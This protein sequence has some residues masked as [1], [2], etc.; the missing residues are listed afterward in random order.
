VL[1]AGGAVLLAEGRSVEVK[2]AAAG[3][4]AAAR[5][6]HCR[7]HRCQRLSKR[8]SLP[9]QHLSKRHQSPVAV[10]SQTWLTT[11]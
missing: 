8:Q 7:F 9:C 3:A 6:Q 2:D 5:R 1:V 10:A 11:L 4:G